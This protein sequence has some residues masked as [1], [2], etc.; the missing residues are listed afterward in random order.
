MIAR[1]NLA[2]QPFRNRTLPWAVA[3]A[4]ACVSLATL[5]YF[6]V[7]SRRLSAEA[8]VTERQVLALRKE[9]DD[10][11]AQAEAI[12][13]TIPPEDLETLK[14]AHTLVDR[15]SFSWSQLFADLE[16][17]LPSG[18]RVS[19]INVREV[20][21][22]GEQTRADLDLIVVGRTSTD[23]TDMMAD[24]SRVG[25]FSAVPVSENQKT[26]KGESGYEL[27][28]RVSY[29]QRSR[30][31]NGDGVAGDQSA[32]VATSARSDLASAIERDVVK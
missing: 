13:E 19:R 23:L 10:L 21:Q 22:R 6:V 24:M 8:D 9:R 20:S 17:A 11:K 31:T 30:K 7:E 29:V 1:L 15:K 32:S 3:V 16:G 18:V 27:T 28:L 5:I 4:V 25:A 14:A 12:K 2:S 26:G